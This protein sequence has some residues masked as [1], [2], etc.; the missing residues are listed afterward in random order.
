[1]I[2]DNPTSV[3]EELDLVELESR[4]QSHRRSWRMLGP[5]VAIH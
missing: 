1:M 3:V 4:G 5:A 2:P